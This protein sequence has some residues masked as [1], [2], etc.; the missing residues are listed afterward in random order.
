MADKIVSL[1]VVVDTASGQANVEN[2]NEDLRDTVKTT[3]KVGTQGK[4]NAAKMSAGFDK[5]GETVGKVN[6]QL[7]GMISGFQAA[8]K[9]ALAFIATP[10]GMVMT[11]IAAAGMAIYQAFKTFQPLIDK[12]EQSFSALKGALSVVRNAMVSVATGAKSLREAISGMGGDM[13]QAAKDAAALMKAQQDLDD[14]MAEQELTTAKTRAEINKLN[15]QAKDR[16]KTEKERLQLLAQAEALEKKDFE[17]R[18]A[19][20][21]EN[22]RIAQEAIRVNSQ[23]T[24]QEFAR[25]QRDGLAFK[26]YAERKGGAQDELFEKLK[27]AMLEMTSLED[28]STVNLEKNFNKRDKLI[29]DQKAKQ[30]KLIEKRKAAE[31]KARAEMEKTQATAK[32]LIETIIDMRIEAKKDIFDEAAF[33]KATHQVQNLAVDIHKAVTP[34]QYSMAETVKNFYYANEQGIKQSLQVASDGLGALADFMEAKEATT[35]AAAK[36]QFERTK[37]LRIAQAIIDT[38]M[39]AQSAFA[40]TPGGIVIKS[41]AAASAALAGLARVRKIKNTKYGGQ[42]DEIGQPFGG[43][44]SSGSVQAQ[45]TGLTPIT[46]QSI[47][48]RKETEPIKVYVTETDIREATGR[49]DDIQSKAVVK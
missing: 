15:V 12:V 17:Q 27:T 3:E 45:S 43:S 2:L 34:I 37:K 48:G 20:A 41:I 24:R 16:T 5:V 36:K 6:P 32:E 47:R 19:I 10:L 18:K 26:E 30:E 44:S 25:L 7:G 33:D 42:S 23:L 49:V 14:V 4:E 31:E 8:T 29:D 38:A 21:A 9:S 39:G 46:P 28:E 35:E 40:D 13:R 22:L 11:A 1:K